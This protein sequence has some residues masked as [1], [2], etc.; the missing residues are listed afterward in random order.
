MGCIQETVKSKAADPACIWAV[1]VFLRSALD[2]LLDFILCS[3]STA[4]THRLLT[5]A[6]NFLGSCTFLLTCVD[7]DAISHKDGNFTALY[8]PTL[9][10]LFQALVFPMQ[11]VGISAAKAILKLTTHG[12]ALLL[13]PYVEEMS[14][15][16][17]MIQL[18]CPLLV[19]DFGHSFP[20]GSPMCIGTKGI[21]VNVISTDDE[22][23]LTVLEA[24][25]RL[26]VQLPPR[27]ADSYITSV[28]NIILQQLDK[29]IEEVPSSGNRHNFESMIVRP[30]KQIC[31]V[32]KFCDVLFMP[33]LPSPGKG[34]DIKK[35]DILLPLLGSIWTAL[36]LVEDVCIKN[37]YQVA[38]DEVFNVYSG[39]L[40]SCRDIVATSELPR[41]GSFIIYVFKQWRRPSAAVCA[42]SALES[43]V[44]L[45]PEVWS[46]FF[47]P[48]VC[49]MALTLPD[50]SAPA[51][52]WSSW[53]SGD[54]DTNGGVLEAYLTLLHRCALL[55]PNVLLSP[56][57]ADS[58]GGI[59]TWKAFDLIA[60]QIFS[61]LNT[62]T[63]LA[64]LRTVMM[65]MQC[66]FS[67]LETPSYSKCDDSNASNTSSRDAIVTASIQQLGEGIVRYI[68]YGMSRQTIPSMLWGISTDTL[69]T[70]IVTSQQSK[71]DDGASVVRMW[72]MNIL[73]D[74]TALPLI[75][76][77]LRHIILEVMV[78]LPV[79]EKRRFKLFLQDVSKIC[80]GEQ[81][82]DTLLDY[83]PL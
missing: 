35:T 34:V 41:L 81:A 63:D 73:S 46:H 24:I 14:L 20:P 55:C 28:G 54:E 8:P 74:A 64:P 62:C 75:P 10:F 49:S 59:V 6:C 32:I 77:E 12:K 13:V 37:N 1:I 18:L 57:S 29:V 67:N 9:S 56:Y 69:I 21:A 48:L 3:V 45:G 43:L 72:L 78:T 33:P 2:R 58:G 66:L 26:L 15:L 40:F 71:S 17:S 25:I 30:L 83:A 5:T 44:I 19:A 42:T 76:S 27:L 60:G 70:V 47:V 22:A 11:I 65:L 79:Y 4:E 80:A 61:I 39:I 82:V 51:A 52:V 7:V 16:Q 53:S 31:K 38:I 50:P 23:V 36:Q 68:I